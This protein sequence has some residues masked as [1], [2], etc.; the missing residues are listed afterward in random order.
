[1]SGPICQRPPGTGRRGPDAVRR[2]PDGVRPRD[3]AITRT[4][5]HHRSRRYLDRTPGP[6]DMPRGA[7]ALRIAARTDPCLSP[8]RDTSSARDGG[9]ERAVSG[10]ASIGGSQNHH[11]HIAKT[12]Q[13]RHICTPRHRLPTCRPTQKRSLNIKVK[14][15]ISTLRPRAR[16]SAARSSSSPAQTARRAAPRLYR[17]GHVR[18]PQGSLFTQ[19]A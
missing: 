5:R 15:C 19:A 12:V 11:S 13:P 9:R 17:M 6:S 3:E 10:T 1:M 4:Q 18:S 2:T 8:I 14:P 7:S 16:A